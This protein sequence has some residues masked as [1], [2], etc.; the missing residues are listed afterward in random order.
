MVTR[1]RSVIGSSIPFES[2]L[3]HRK[4][5]SDT[6]LADDLLRYIITIAQGTRHHRHVETGASP[7]ATIAL[8]RAAQS[9]AYLRGR[10]FVIPEDIKYLAPFVLAHRLTLSIEGEI[11]TSKRKVI[12]EVIDT[13]AVPVESGM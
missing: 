4:A 5:V 7:R 1:T 11:K 6:K 8:A 2:L 12:Q 3:E 13:V 10:T 9:L